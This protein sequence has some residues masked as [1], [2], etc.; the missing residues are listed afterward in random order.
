MSSSMGLPLRKVSQMVLVTVAMRL[1][2]SIATDSAIYQQ[3]NEGKWRGRT[4][5]TPVVVR[6]EEEEGTTRE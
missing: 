1:P 5:Q 2:D 6:K 4:C 3:H